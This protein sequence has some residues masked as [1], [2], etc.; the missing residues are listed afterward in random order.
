VNKIHYPDFQK[1]LEEAK[2]YNAIP[3]YSEIRADFETPLSI[4]I[5]SRAKFLLESVEKGENVG[6][7]SIITLGTKCTI[8]AKGNTISIIEN[9]GEPTLTISRN[10]ANPLIEVRK[11]FSRFQTPSYEGLPPF[12]GGAIGYI[13]YEAVHYF[14]NIPVRENSEGIPDILMVI[15]ET[16]LIYDSVKRTV[17]IIVTT[18]PRKRPEEEYKRAI[19][20][21]EAL[22]GRLCR[23]LELP[24]NEPSG[25][26]SGFRSNLSKDDFL[27]GVQRCKTYIQEGDVIQ[28]VLSRK[29]RFALEADLFE[30]YKALR[31]INPSPYL[32]FLDFDDFF[33]IGSS[34]EV[35]VKVQN[36]ELLIKPIAGTRPRGATVSEDNLISRELL[37]DEKERAEHIMLVDLARNDLGRVSRP[38]SVEVTDFMSIEKYSHVMH[39]VSTVKSEMDATRDVFDVIMATF[40][41]GTLTGA[42]KIRAM[43]I[44]RELEP[45]RRGIYGGMVFYLGFNGNMDSCITIRTIFIKDG[46]ATVQ[47]GAGIVADSIP[48]NEYEESR[49]KAKALLKAIEKTCQRRSP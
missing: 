3:V 17:T 10:V 31:I 23:N 15:P 37:A 32:F 38:G 22:E 46:L 5:K 36:G 40:P 26:W 35:M 49:N 43:E 4:F 6:R 47:A 1:Y 7:Y 39:I 48:E 11:Y 16:L 34:P 25:R 30:V 9:N 21:I 20:I 29:F 33:L 28:V 27:E 2:K 14:E 44:I 24:G 42:P 19:Q 45:E 8:K 13:G 12:F 18:F 41:A